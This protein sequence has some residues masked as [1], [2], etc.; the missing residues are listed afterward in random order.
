VTRPGGYAQP[1]SALGPGLRTGRRWNLISRPPPRDGP[2]FL[3]LSCA[4]A[5]A[6]RRE[7]GP[8]TP[9][10]WGGYAS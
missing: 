2:P 3:E 8:L 5:G 4:D 1:G 7:A 9:G 6:W 10:R